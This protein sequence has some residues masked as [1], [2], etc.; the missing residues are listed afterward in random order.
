MIRRPPRSTLF[1]YTTLFRAAFGH[2]GP[3]PAAPPTTDPRR[4]PKTC[5]RYRRLELAFL[6][7]AFAG[8]FLLL[9]FS[10]GFFGAGRAALAGL[11]LP[12]AE[13]EAAFATAPA[14]RSAAC[15]M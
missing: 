4:G 13:A 1:P 2:R 11:A 9:A 10:A 14:R 8:A 3:P 15:I 6:A 12:P 7:A 5:R